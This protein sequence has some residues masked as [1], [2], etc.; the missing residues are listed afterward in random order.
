MFLSVKNLNREIL[1]K[2]LVTFKRYD[3]GNDEEC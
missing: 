2:N 3:E 1:A